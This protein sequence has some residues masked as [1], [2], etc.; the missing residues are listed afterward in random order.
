MSLGA[1]FQYKREN[2]NTAWY[3]DLQTPIQLQ[4]HNHNYSTASFGPSSSSANLLAPESGFM[5]RS[6]SISSTATGHSSYDHHTAGFN[7]ST[8]ALNAAKKARPKT[9]Y[10]DFIVGEKKLITQN[11][12]NAYDIMPDIDLL[13]NSLPEKDDALH[14]PGTLAPRFGPDRR[15]GEPKNYKRSG[16]PFSSRG[17]LNAGAL[18]I[19]MCAVSW[20]LLW[21]R[22]SRSFSQENMC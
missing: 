7:G 2:T 13:N 22:E 21:T 9:R 19:I 20:A 4:M 18:V 12:S 15:I 16:N 17:L 14:D 6:N 11:N 8:N 1:E 5:S 3:A 10:E